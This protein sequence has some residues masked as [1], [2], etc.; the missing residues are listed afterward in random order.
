MIARTAARDRSRKR[1]RRL[2]YPAVRSRTDSR[3]HTL[4]RRLSFDP[5]IGNP[6]SSDRRR[7]LRRCPLP[8]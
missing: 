7:L 1:L 6:F 4:V 3:E 5:G 8:L 2:G